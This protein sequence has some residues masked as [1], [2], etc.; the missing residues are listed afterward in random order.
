MAVAP[1]ALHLLARLLANCCS[2][3]TRSAIIGMVG[4]SRFDA[5]I[6]CLLRMHDTAWICHRHRSTPCISPRRGHPC[7]GICL[8]SVSCLHPDLAPTGGAR[9]QSRYLAQFID[10]HFWLGILA[11]NVT[12]GAFAGTALPLLVFYRRLSF[13]FLP[14][15][16][17]AVAAALLC[18]VNADS[19]TGVAGAVVLTILLFLFRRALRMVGAQRRT[20]IMMTLGFS[21][22]LLLL[23]IS[24]LLN[25]LAAYLDK[26]QDLTGRADLWPTINAV[27]ASSP[28]GTILGYGY[29]AGLRMFVAPAIQPQLGFEPS[30][31][32]NGYLDVVVAIGYLG[33]TIVFLVHAWLFSRSKRLLLEAPTNSANLAALPMSLLLTGVFLNYGESLLM[34]SSSVFTQL[35]ALIAVWLVSRPAG[36]SPR[37]TRSHRGFEVQRRS[38]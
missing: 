5:A 11:H 29:V 24:G 16:L 32:H 35:T 15:W 13:R 27:V 12:L 34:S 1:K 28:L 36:S 20:I 37:P 4:L 25:W 30:D 14:V 21:L 22:L 3:D 7:L 9:G 23:M 18:L 31:L 8:H 10:E 2:S 19:M 33:A 6:G 26:S 38:A 17:A